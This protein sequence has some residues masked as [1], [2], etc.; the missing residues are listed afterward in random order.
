MSGTKEGKKRKLDSSTVSDLKYNA[1]FGN[2]VRSEALEGALPKGQHNPQRCPYGLYAE[3]L[4]GT[5]FT[6]PRHCNQRTWMYRIRPSVQHVPFHEMDHLFAT[7]DFGRGGKGGKINPN[8]MRWMPCDIPS[9]PT[10]FVSGLRTMGGSG[11]PSERE[12]LAIHMYVANIGMGNSAM[13][14]ADGD[15]LIVPQLGTL[16]IRTE[17]G[18]LRVA[19]KEICVI[20]R[21]MRFN[22]DLDGP[23]R[24]YILEIFGGHFTLPDLG[25]IGSNVRS[26]FSL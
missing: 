20:Q 5:A 19:P 25:P 13:S 23:S 11:D 22:V 4:S 9:K 17:F 7:N 16:T 15:F 10:D 6:R 12:G 24:G 26:P 1:G 8:Q 21:G 18:I 2:Y 3:Q 14:N